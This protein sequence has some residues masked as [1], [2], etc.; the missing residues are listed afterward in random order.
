MKYLSF[1]FLTLILFIA[2]GCASKQ[3][4]LAE[5]RVIYTTDGSGVLPKWVFDNPI[6]EKD[7]KMLISGVVDIA[8]N[9]SPSRGLTAA[10]LQAR[11]EIAKQIKTRIAVKLQYAN[12]GFGYDNQVLSQ[13]VS[14]ASD[15]THMVNVRIVERGFAKIADT[16]NYGVETRYTCYSRA[17]IEIE[18]LKKMIARALQDAQQQ[19]KISEEFKQKVEKEWNRFFNDAN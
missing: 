5:H 17:S 15:T 10:D 13:I 6:Q 12:E 18:E 2:Q 4:N 19:G 14:Q 11:A 3:S 9:Q 1:L 7:G 16:G 8:G